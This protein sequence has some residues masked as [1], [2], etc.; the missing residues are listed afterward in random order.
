MHVYRICI[1]SNHQHFAV[2]KASMR[3]AHPLAASLDKALS[4]CVSVTSI[5]GPALIFM[6]TIIDIENHTDNHDLYQH[7]YVI[8][9]NSSRLE[10]LPSSPALISNVRGNVYVADGS[11]NTTANKTSR[12]N[13]LTKKHFI[14]GC[15]ALFV[16]TV[17]L[18]IIGLFSIPTVY[19]ALPPLNLPKVRDLIWTY[20]SLASSDFMH[21]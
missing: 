9:F 19:N 7:D 6:A 10:P 1:N 17:M 3:V 13:K 15:E 14:R 4:V 2:Y 11:V 20:C 5:P 18:V 16:T 12:S 8:V 21:A